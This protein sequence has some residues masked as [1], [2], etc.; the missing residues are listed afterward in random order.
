MARRSSGGVS[1]GNR[2]SVPLVK[3]NSMALELGAGASRMGTTVVIG[4]LC[5]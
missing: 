2:T 4:V 3:T 5:L 1:V